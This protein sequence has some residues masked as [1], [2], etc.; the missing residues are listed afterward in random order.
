MED[1]NKV[2]TLGL[3]SHLAALYGWMSWEFWNH[4]AA[5]VIW[6]LAAM[7]MMAHIHDRISSKRKANKP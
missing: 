3:M 1:N 2:S 7:F 6:T 4:T 5:A